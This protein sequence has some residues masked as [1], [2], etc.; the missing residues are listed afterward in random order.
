MKL[1]VFC[2]R[3]GAYI[4]CV[5][6]GM[7]PEGSLHAVTLDFLSSKVKFL[8]NHVKKLFDYSFPDGVSLEQS[9]S[10]WC[11]RTSRRLGCKMM[12]SNH[13]HKVLPSLEKSHIRQFFPPPW[14]YSKLTC[15]FCHTLQLTRLLAFSDFVKLYK[16]LN[17]SLVSFSIYIFLI[18]HIL[19]IM[20]CSLSCC[21]VSS[22]C[23][24]HRVS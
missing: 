16:G 2:W 11:W 15:L 8:P 12:S 6:K 22:I 3:N 21:H 18:S 24:G 7:F 20:T 5:Q 1:D 4:I 17:Y 10:W 14:T 9:P 23:F 13:N 19:P